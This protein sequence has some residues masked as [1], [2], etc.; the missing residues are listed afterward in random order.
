MPSQ[1]EIASQMVSAL[2]VTIPDLDTSIGTPTRKILDAVAEVVA[3][4]YVDQFFLG[5]NYDITS[6][7]GSSL[8]DFVNLFGMTRLT[9][10]RATGVVTFAAPAAATQAT[11]VPAG[12]AV[13]TYD[14]PPVTFVTLITGV[15]PIGAISID[16]PIIAQVGGSNGNVPPNSIAGFSTPLSGFSTLANTT[17]TTGGADA[18]S[19]DALRN[20][21]ENTVFRNMAGTEQMFLGT[22][23]ENPATVMAN[24]IGAAKTHLEQIQITGGTGQSTI[25]AAKYIYP[26]NYVFGPSIA[27]QSLL[28]PNIHYTFNANT[29]ALAAPG[30]A[31]QTALT[32]A[33]L[34]TGGTIPSGRTRFYRIAYATAAGTTPAGA[35]VAAAATTTAA[36]S[37]RLT[38][39]T[40]VPI[41][42]QWIYVYGSNTTNTETLL[43]IVAAS[44]TTW[45][46]TTG[47]TGT[48]AY[49]TTNTAGY[50]PTITSI[51]AV[52]C[53]DGVYDFQFQY[54]P[55]ASRNDPVN[56]V[57]NKIDIYVQGADDQS[58]TDTVIWS[59]GQVFNSNAGDPLNYTSYAHPD[60][61]RPTPGN[62]FLPLTFQ[63]VVGLPSTITVS[64][65]GGVAVSGSTNTVGSVIYA[66]DAGTGTDVGA[67][68]YYYGIDY[69][70]VNNITSIGGS[71]HSNSGIEWRSVA[72]GGN[73][74]PPANAQ[75]PVTYSYNAVPREIETAIQRWRLVTTDVW[76]HQSKQM[77]LNTTF[78]VVLASGYTASSVLGDVQSAMQTAFSG[79][80]FDGILSTSE[81]LTAVGQVAGILAVRFATQ[82]DATAAGSTNWAIQQINSAAGL[83]QTF[84]YG[85]R[86]TDVYFPDDTVPVFNN[87]NLYVRAF[88]TYMTGA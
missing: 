81:L 6:L 62:Y 23:Q 26:M 55:M 50:S 63:P 36:S 31:P 69:F 4:A 79:V 51:D 2:G 73:P 88:N 56:G 19:D 64:A 66:A 52:N 13:S 48:Q 7:S 80:G 20:R 86:A 44:I 12:T 25:Q 1:P 82:A 30:T 87:A 34:T 32:A 33:T 24:V 67:I 60:L 78:V 68:T 37:V 74:L 45:T 43:A 17:A 83:I 10:R 72:N 76:V 84:S 71:P 29:Y 22:A 21:F 53:P 18:E 75:L 41:Q 11:S 9:A 46:D 59:T 38:F 65:L 49:P 77:F 47:A 3:E 57:T 54:V 35:E 5:Y 15:M 70:L 61:T 85:G 40:P 58:A 16:I 27:D 28:N 42:A 14:S 8:D 39:P